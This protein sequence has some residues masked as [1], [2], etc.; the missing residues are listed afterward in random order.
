MSLLAV[1]VVAMQAMAFEPDPVYHFTGGDI[2]LLPSYEKYNTPYK[3]QNGQTIP[4]LISWL[5]D[6]CH[7]NTFR[8]RIF[9]NPVDTKKEGVVQD[10]AY[11]KPLAKRIKDKGAFLML[12]FHYSDT[13]VDATHIQAP[14]GWQ[15]L[16]DSLMADTL[17]KYTAMVLDELNAIGATPDFVQVGNEIMYGLCG[18]KVHPYANATDNW[19][20]YVGL[21][22]AGC[23][24]VR[25]KCPEAKIIIHSDRPT[26]KQYNQFYYQK[27]IDMGVDYDIIGLSYYPFWHGYLNAAQVASKSDKSNLADAL[28]QLAVDFP[29]KD[30]HIVETA[31]NYQYWPTSGVNYNTQDVWPCSKVGQYNFVGDLIAELKWNHKNVKGINYWFPEENGNGG[32][33]W[34]ANTIVIQNWLSRGLWDD[35]NH[36]LNTGGNSTKTPAHALGLFPA[37]FSAVENVEETNVTGK[38]MVNGVLVIERGGKTYTVMGECVNL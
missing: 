18:I 35:N 36:S 7:W 9:V 6:E 13:W 28:T 19:A 26:N 32:P 21:L 34:N 23:A 37:P 31:Y 14:V 1:A 11:V 8:V 12:D 10:L 25:E 24:A 33:T 38:R 5:V 22:K 15:G 3:D 17:G 27:L 16:S 29:D 4:D 20:G 2:S 30:V